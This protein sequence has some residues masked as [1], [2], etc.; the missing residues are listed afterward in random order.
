[1]IVDEK[2]NEYELTDKGSSAGKNYTGGTAAE[3]ISSCSI[4]VMN[5]IRVDEDP[6]LDERAKMPSKAFHQEKKTPNEK[7]AHTI[8]GSCF[9][10][11]C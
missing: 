5:I 7:S 3:K 2:S 9:A 10:P 11:I 8:Y 4:S 6:D 1:M